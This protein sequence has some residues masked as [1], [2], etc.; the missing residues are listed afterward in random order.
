MIRR[1]AHRCARVA[2]A[3]AAC[4][5]RPS[6]RHPVGTAHRI[7]VAASAVGEP[8]TFEACQWALDGEAEYKYQAHQAR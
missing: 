1:A 6:E 4:P 2:A 8:P 5:R 3:V 7:C